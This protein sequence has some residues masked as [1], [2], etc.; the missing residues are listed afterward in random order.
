MG[1]KLFDFSFCRIRV[2]M[3]KQRVLQNPSH[4]LADGDA[5]GLYV[6]QLASIDLV[7]LRSGGFGY[8]YNH[9]FSKPVSFV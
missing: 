3:D 8:S 1:W 5:Q 7:F 9:N 6:V 4:L 2:A